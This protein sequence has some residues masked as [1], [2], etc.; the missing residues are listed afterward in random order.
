V[1]IFDDIYV[2]S[3]A[4]S[5]TLASLTLGHGALAGRL[6]IASHGQGAWYSLSYDGQNG[7]LIVGD[8][9]MGLPGSVIVGALGSG[10]GVFVLDAKT[11]SLKVGAAH[12]ANGSLTISTGRGDEVVSLRADDSA[13]SLRKAGA[14]E[15]VKLEGAHG[16]LIL[17]GN[18]EDG[19]ITVKMATGEN[20]VVVSGSSGMI[21]VGGMGAN[22]DIV[23]KNDHNIDTIRV[24][25]SDGDIEFVNADVAE[26]FEVDES[27][28][29]DAIPGTVMTLD[30]DSRL[31]PSA[32][33]YDPRVVGVV[34]GAGDCRPGIVLGRTG[35]EHRLPVAMVGRAYC[36][37]DAEEGP[38]AVGDMLTTSDTRGHA[39]RAADRE[40]AFGAVIGKALSPH[41]GGAGLIPVLVALQ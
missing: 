27:A 11:S 10:R 21:T 26:D 22:G 30:A 18:G 32:E 17:G 8:V 31:V 33:A 40:R 24:T 6:L 5:P 29:A 1:T 23:V 7:T 14:L 16:N 3:P 39:M 20:A 4:E 41:A 38:V 36:R 28:L 35:A 12:T 9:Q 19:D 34:A 2:E 25:G 13:L 37:V 15:T